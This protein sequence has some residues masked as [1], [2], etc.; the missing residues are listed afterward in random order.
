M[1]LKEKRYLSYYFFITIFTTTI[2][3][4]FFITSTTYLLLLFISQWSVASGLLDDVHGR[5]LQPDVIRWSVP[6]AVLAWLG[7]RTTGSVN[8]L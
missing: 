1:F 3:T 6:S 7:G 8:E 2:F 4:T 5:F